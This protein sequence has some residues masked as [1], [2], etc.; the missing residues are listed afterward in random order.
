MD[1]EQIL[2]LQFCRIHN[3]KNNSSDGSTSSKDCQIPRNHTHYI[4]YHKWHEPLHLAM[5]P[6]PCL[7]FVQHFPKTI[8]S[9]KTSN[10]Q[11]QLGNHLSRGTES[12]GR[13]RNPV[14]TPGEGLIKAL[15]L[16]NL[17]LLFT[18]FVFV[19]KRKV[20]SPNVHCE[21]SSSLHK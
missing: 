1:S 6:L 14:G 4:C 18:L 3:R 20:F 21:K 11:T 19:D 9:Q 7:L 2:M 8:S 17:G 12:A 13:D 5:Q 10:T 15:D 16:M